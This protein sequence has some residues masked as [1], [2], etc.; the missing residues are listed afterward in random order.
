MKNILF[1][2][3]LLQFTSCNSQHSFKS[4]GPVD[5]EKG[6]S[7]P[8][9]QL[10]DVRTTEEYGDK[11][12]ANAVNINIDGDNFEAEMKRL[13]KNKPTYIYCLAGSRSAKASDWAW[14]N[15]FK[16][17]YNLEEGVNSW[18]KSGKPLVDAK[19]ETIRRTKGMTFDEYLKRIKSSDKLVLVDFNA[20][21]CGPCKTLK[22]IVL[23]IAKKYST[24][25]DLLDIDVDMHADV[26]NTMNIQSIPM[27]LVY[28]QGK[29]VW[30]N[31]GLVDEDVLDDKLK[32]LS[33]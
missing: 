5:F 22:P 11:H 24:K 20:V 18:I 1:L 33:N 6:L 31:L 26:S 2:F 21:W 25:V 30:R 13:D 23:R 27:L 32:E 16:Q 4:I 15:G 29:E 9:I 17:V 8:G 7:Q 14:S 19:G 3:L 10:V 28:K 12:I